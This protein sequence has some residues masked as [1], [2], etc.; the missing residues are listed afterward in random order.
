MFGWK[1]IAG[2]IVASIAT[3][4]VGFLLL[5]A[6]SRLDYGVF[7]IDVLVVLIVGGV[8]GFLYGII[9]KLLFFVKRS[10]RAEIFVII[11]SILLAIT[12]KG[13][14]LVG[15][16]LYNFLLGYISVP[17]LGDFIVSLISSIFWCVLMIGFYTPLSGLGKKKEKPSILGLEAIPISSK[18]ESSLN[19]ILGPV[20]KTFQAKPAQQ[21]PPGYIV[22]PYCGT[23]NEPGSRFCKNCGRPL[24]RV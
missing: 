9:D 6:T 21:V 7:V 1:G 2:G 14:L 8:L 19:F 24:A 17:L 4:V 3:L 11:I 15:Q 16:G 13:S 22:C 10:N 5:T 20:K 23:V 18:K 12:G